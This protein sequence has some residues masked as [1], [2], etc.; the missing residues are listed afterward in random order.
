MK[1]NYL[2]AGHDQPKVA[3]VSWRLER[4]TRRKG[5]ATDEM[6]TMYSAPS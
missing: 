3:A 4:W 5:P 1:V 6:T 2:T